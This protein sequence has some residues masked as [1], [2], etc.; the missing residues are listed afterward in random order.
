MLSLHNTPGS[1]MSGGG[2]ATEL[3]EDKKDLVNGSRE[4]EAVVGGDRTIKR[5][6]IASL[7][8]VAIVKSL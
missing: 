2:S 1:E 6:K 4:A 7:P 5:Y 8:T 3:E